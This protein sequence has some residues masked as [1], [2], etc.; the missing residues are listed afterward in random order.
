MAAPLSGAERQAA[1]PQ[2]EATREASTATVLAEEE[3]FLNTVAAASRHV[4][5]R[6][7]V[8]RAEGRHRLTGS[9]RS[10]PPSSR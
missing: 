1:L 4:Q 3:K 6:V 2:L 8:A 9:G 10:G 7:E 5:E